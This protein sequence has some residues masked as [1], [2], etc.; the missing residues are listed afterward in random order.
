ML[1]DPGIA[2]MHLSRLPRHQRLGL[3][4]FDGDSGLEIAISGFADEKSLSRRT[5]RSRTM[6]ALGCHGFAKR[7]VA[8][9]L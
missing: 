1:V 7:G 9:C 8:I 4:G 2:P 5:S 6:V 3:I